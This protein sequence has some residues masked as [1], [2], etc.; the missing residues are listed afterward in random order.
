MKAISTIQEGGARRRV[1]GSL[2]A[3]GAALLG[4]A[5]GR[6]HAKTD[7]LAASAV[8]VA[9]SDQARLLAIEEIRLLKARYCWAMDNQDWKA[10]RGIFA[11]NAA[12][13]FTL[14][15]GRTAE[16]P[17]ALVGFL[18]KAMT[19][20]IQ[21]RHQAHNFQITFTSATEAVGQWHHES[22]KWFE[23]LSQPNMHQ[24]GEYRERYTKTSA[25]W[26]VSFFTETNVRTAAAE[27]S[28]RVAPALA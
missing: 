9:M 16:T 21:T 22:W 10:L 7:T 6:A 14:P 8:P 26:R 23:D 28:R 25:G 1:L 24:W 18:A 13:H 19:P 11:A 2:L 5:A 12:V 15:D 20:N 17:D 3:M 4:G 27:W